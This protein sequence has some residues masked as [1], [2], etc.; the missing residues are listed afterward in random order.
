MNRDDELR[1]QAQY[2]LTEVLARERA[3]LQAVFDTSQA[4]ML[5][6]N[7]DYLVVRINNAAKLNLGIEM[8]A[9]PRSVEPAREIS[10][11][12][13]AQLQTRRTGEGLKS[14]EH[15]LELKVEPLR[16]VVEE[17][18]T[19]G[20]EINSREIS[21]MLGSGDSTPKSIWLNVSAKQIRQDGSVVALLTLIDTTTQKR[22]E[23][24][25]RE[26]NLQ[27]RRLKERAE[28]ETRAKSDFLANISHE[29][30]TPIASILGFA[31]LIASPHEI[32]SRDADWANRIVKNARHL[33]RLL[34]D[35][36]D[37][38][39]IEAGRMELRTETF[40]IGEI[41]NAAA[42]TCRAEACEKGLDVCVSTSPLVPESLVGDATRVRQ[43]IVNLL[44]NAVKFTSSGSIK[45]FVDLVT[46]RGEDSMLRVR[47]EDT[48][49]GMNGHQ[50]DRLFQPFSRVH[51]RRLE[52]GGTGLGLAISKRIAEML[53]GRIEVTSLPDVG[54]CF[55]LKLPV[56]K[57]KLANFGYVPEAASKRI[58]AEATRGKKVLIADDNPDGRELYRFMLRSGELDL[59]LENDGQAAIDR[60]LSANEKF[61]L[62]LL[63]MDMPVKTGFEAAAELRRKGVDTPILAVTAFAMSHHREQCLAAGCD[64]ILAKPFSMQELQSRVGDLLRTDASDDYLLGSVDDDPEFA[65]LL[66]KYMSSLERH[67]G[68]ILDAETQNRPELI[69]NVV[70][71]LRGT[72]LS[73]GFASLG[74]NA[75][76]CHDLLEQGTD[77]HGISK[78]L[79]ELKQ[80]IADVLASKQLL[81]AGLAHTAGTFTAPV[82]SDSSPD[83]S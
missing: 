15:V 52:A 11:G 60:V 66:E 44:S 51:D 33:R 46:D 5:L 37:M 78:H 43:V 49:I 25:M 4:G 35:L 16:R 56:H 72:A 24:E 3:N 75:A 42:E 12:P 54:S 80:S 19:R 23:E 82:D 2:Q 48:G 22:I 68:T 1:V 36:L 8:D 81:L 64:A 7:D 76:A 73:F 32:T 17:V 53:G 67:L 77:M 34:D 18:L 38:K 70:H 21:V 29:L 50:V 14:R 83:D 30:R 40:D 45:L 59:T 6:V 79:G 13:S 26:S 61:D 69:R 57:N 58:N 71:K 55:T 62:I 47:V 20:I 39:K 74:A 31:D 65:Q 9:D 63:D 10:P 41:V 27:L 28:A